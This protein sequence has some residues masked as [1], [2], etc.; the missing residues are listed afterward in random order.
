VT[1]IGIFTHQAEGFGSTRYLLLEIAE[2]WRRQGLEV[3]QHQG[4][5][6]PPQVDLGIAHVDLTVT[7]EPYIKLISQIPR[8]LNA[9]V[10][11]ISKHTISRH[12]V[13]LGDGYEG[14]VFVKTNCNFGGLQELSL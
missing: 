11:D 13:T 12:R 10:T 4:L 7:P 6:S 8:T 1:R 2:L 9:R 5:S 14:P 3:L